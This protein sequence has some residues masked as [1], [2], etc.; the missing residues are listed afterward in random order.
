MGEA[1][2]L[3]REILPGDRKRRGRRRSETA[4]FFPKA[5]R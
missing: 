1:I 3:K 2:S 5:V 4:E